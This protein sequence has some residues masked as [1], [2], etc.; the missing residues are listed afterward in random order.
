[1]D[2][3]EAKK[4]IEKLKEKIKELNYQYFV[5]DNSQVEESV[6]DSLKRELIELETKFPEYI[7][8]DSPTQRVGST[9]S[10]RFAKKKHTTAKKS[11][12]DVFSEEEIMEWYER[13]QKLVSKP[14][15][16]VC[17]LKIDGLNITVL[18][19]KGL[20]KRALTRGNGIEGEDVTHTVR[21]IKSIPLSLNEKIELEASGEVFISKKEF[22]R[23][24]EEQAKNN[25]PLFAN[26]RN[27]AAGS[28]RQLDPSVASNRNLDMFFY[29]IDK[30][31][32]NNINSQQESLKFL[33]KMGLK[34][35][36]HYE[37]L[38]SIEKVVKFCHKW[39]EKRHELPYEIDGIVIKVNDFDQQQ[40][41]G[42]TA[43]APRYAVAYKFP[44]EQVSSRILDII[45]QVG[46]TGAITPVAVM[47][48]TLV[49]GSVVSRATLHNEDEIR[50]KD[51]RIGDTVI[52]QKAGDV[53][54]EVVEVLK[55]LRTGSEKTFKFP[56]E[57]P[58]CG[59]EIMRKEGEAAYRCINPRCYAIEREAIIHFVSKK[60]FNIDGLG[61]KV[62]IQLIDNNIISKPDDIFRIEKGDLLTLDLFQEKRADNLVASIEKAKN[63]NLE[64][65]LFSL[66][67]RHLGEQSSYD[68][69]KYLIG[70]AKKSIKKLERKKKSTPEPTLFEVEE[71]TISEEF[72]ILDLLETVSSFS[73]EE[74]TNIDGI[75]EKMG[76]SISHWF[77]DH[78]HQEL[79]ENLYQLGISLKTEQLKTTGKLEGKNFVLTGSL[80]N[81]TRDQAKQLIKNSGGKVH[82]SLTKDTD[83]VVAGESPGS[84]YNKAKELGLKI[85]TEEEF[86]NMV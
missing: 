51:I 14:L 42:Y 36:G 26:T 85:I 32:S 28:V 39:Q 12:A 61:E 80:E 75:G 47:Q 34:I 73:P 17:E 15:D 38:D 7:T 40:A 83:F 56:K 37:H 53:I 69:A 64:A 4:R 54:P 46:R 21:T 55:D 63:I 66:G 76:S 27:T 9:L 23:I 8:E 24:N 25:K 74:I 52:I 84:K 22:E 13:I 78:K 1:M 68:F 11:L 18:Y 60:G 57:C 43:K 30:N 58:V 77:E 2:Q 19:E 82:S 33:K 31:T 67:I 6:R 81:L 72:S 48:P 16:F 41:M 49:A 79:L 44:A 5:L 86:R 70:H 71:Q 59:S 65:F 3:K 20:L 10:G 35:C 50:R 45:L 29:S 62:V